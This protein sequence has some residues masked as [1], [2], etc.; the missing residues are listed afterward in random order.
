MMILLN[1]IGFYSLFVSFFALSFAWFE[2]RQTYLKVSADFQI[3]G[4]L[5]IK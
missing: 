5:W 3:F 2:L 1:M 4:L